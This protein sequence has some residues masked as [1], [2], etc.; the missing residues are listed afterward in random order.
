MTAN[1]LLLL[2]VPMALMLGAIFGLTGIGHGLAGLGK[3]EAQRLLFARAGLAMPYIAAAGI[4]VIF[5][6]ATA[7]SASIRAA[8]WSVVNK[9]APATSV[10]VRTMP[11]F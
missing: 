2:I 7:G 5:L 4:G 8:A 11:A 3:T 6:F 10:F 9:T 1:R